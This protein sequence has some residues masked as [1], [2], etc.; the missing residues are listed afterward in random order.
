M[1]VRLACVGRRR[2]ARR[3]FAAQEGRRRRPSTLSLFSSL[4]PRP[5]TAATTHT[6]S[7]PPPPRVR[8]SSEGGRA[9]ARSAPAPRPAPRLPLVAP[10]PPLLPRRR[11]AAMEC[12]ICLC[13]VPPGGEAFLQ[14]CFHFFCF[15]CIQEW[16]ATQRSAAAAARAGG[17]AAAASSGPEPECPLCKRAIDS[18]IHDCRDHA[19]R[20][21]AGAALPLVRCSPPA[22]PPPPGGPAASAPPSA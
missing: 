17:A 7:P 13:D 14:P 22:R 2:G 20:R 16:A 9:R 15:G 3:L 18:I 6:H 19:F 8:G 12:A 11:R 10:P 4:C 1:S 5:R 21:A